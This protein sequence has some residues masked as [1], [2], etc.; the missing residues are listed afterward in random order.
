MFQTTNQLSVQWT[1]IFSNE[2]CSK[3]FKTRCHSILLAGWFR[4]IHTSWNMVIL[5]IMASINHEPT[6][7]SSHCSNG[8]PEAS[9]AFP[10]AVDVPLELCGWALLARPRGHSRDLG[11]WWCVLQ[12]PPSRTYWRS[13]A[14]DLSCGHGVLWDGAVDVTRTPGVKPLVWHHHVSI[15][16]GFHH[17]CHALFHAYFHGQLHN[18]LVDPL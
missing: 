12:T 6:G 15:I 10:V 9:N 5:N 18:S 11:W 2:Q 3:L 7:V 13:P 8:A 17:P 4:R 14:S 16:P 1:M